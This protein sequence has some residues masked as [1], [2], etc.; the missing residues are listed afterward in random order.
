MKRW[1]CRI[2]CLA[3]CFTGIRLNAEVISWFSDANKINLT[4][5]GAPMDAG[6]QFELGVFS[7]GFVPTP[8]NVSEWPA[9]WVAADS[10]SYNATTHR[11]AGQ[12]TVTDNASP[13]LI[14]A[15]AWIFGHRTTPTGTDRILLRNTQWIWPAPDPLNPIPTEWNA[16]TANHVVLGNVDPGGSPFL[17]KSARGQSFTQWQTELL[18]GEPLAGPSDDPDGDGSSNLLEF[19]FGTPPK[20]AGP[21]TATP[22][23]LAGGH[24]QIIIPRRPDRPALLTVEVSG[25]LAD[26]QSGPTVTQLVDDGMDALI[27][28]DLV[29]VDP[30]HPRRFMRLKAEPAAP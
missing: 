18:T 26:W 1:T 12:W 3:G 4:A 24:T 20:S 10:T 23:T 19:I 22:V 16:A 17:M 8:L 27:V 7:A 13:F 14:G 6:F 15:A 29:P 30:V 2:L 28:R 25:N 11:F 9:Y 5:A 21:H